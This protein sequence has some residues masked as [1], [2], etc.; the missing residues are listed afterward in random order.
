MMKTPH[1]RSERRVPDKS[2]F[3]AVATYEDGTTAY[4]WHPKSDDRDLLLIARERQATGEIPA[5]TIVSARR[6][7]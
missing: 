7:R 2:T 3:I 1:F 6:A 4:L 5:G